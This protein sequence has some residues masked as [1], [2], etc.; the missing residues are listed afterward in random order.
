[1]N[2][3][4]LLTDLSYIDRKLIEESETEAIGGKS[5]KTVFKKPLLIA[6]ILTLMVF[7]LGCAVVAL[8]LEDL[9][10]GQRPYRESARYNEAGE[11]IPA[12]ERV[13]DVISLQGIEGSANHQAAQEWFQFR[14]SYDPEHKLWNGEFQ[15]PPEYD[16]YGVYTQ[17]MMDKLLEICQK[18]DLKP[19]GRGVTESYADWEMVQTALDIDGFLKDGAMAE[20]RYDG[21]H[22]WECGNFN[23]YFYLTLTDPESALEDELFVN[24]LYC[25]K[26][27]FDDRFAT[28]DPE[29]A[30]QWN[31]TLEDGTTLLI[32]A[33]DEQAHILCDRPD[34]FISIYLPTVWDR[35]DGTEGTISREDIERVAKSIDFSIRTRPVE[36]M[37]WVIARVEENVAAQENWTEDPAVT[38]ERKRVFEENERKDS[39]AELIAQ[40]RD[41]EE[42]FTTRGSGSFVAYQDF[43]ESKAY[44]LMDVTGDGEDE[45]LLGQDGSILAIWTMEDGKT[46]FLQGTNATGNLCEGNVFR[47][48]ELVDGAPY[49]WFFD[50]T[51]G[52]YRLEAVEYRRYED[53]WYHEDYRPQ[54]EATYPTDPSGTT[55]TST[56]GTPA[57]VITEEE[58]NEIVQSYTIIPVEMTPVKDFPGL[59]DK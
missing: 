37:D 4:E 42:Y 38:A 16:S 41:N 9:R 24:Y 34:A 59:S 2:G 51:D 36:D 6:A 58:A 27:Y 26:A 5:G 46:N 1:M 18:Y 15:V 17:E 28:V 50:L 22:L 44:A 53:S 56:G 19:L 21:G 23:L 29:K 10:I 13:H 47:H 43:W 45:L 55:V 7:L 49:Y 8:H 12:S 33:D 52:G 35:L 32:V 31:L 54:Q 39:Y 48:Y 14:Q 57:V 11:K 3:K 20:E 25:G 30:Q 40:M